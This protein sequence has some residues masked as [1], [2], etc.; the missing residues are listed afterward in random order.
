MK[1]PKCNCKFEFDFSKCPE[2]GY[3]MSYKTDDTSTKPR[4]TSKVIIAAACAAFVIC[5]GTIGLAKLKNNSI[6]NDSKDDAS[7]ASTLETSSAEDNS[8][9]AADGADDSAAELTAEDYKKGGDYTAAESMKTAAASYDPESDTHMYDALKKEFEENYYIEMSTQGAE[10]TFAL[11]DGEI[12][13]SSNYG[14]GTYSGYY[15]KDKD[16]YTISE[17]TKS[18]SKEADFDYD[19]RNSD[20]LFGGTADFI[21]AEID[22]NGNISEVYAIDEDFTQASGTIRY[23]FNKDTGALM[24]Y[25]IT[26]DGMA[27]TFYTIDMLAECADENINL[28]DLSE[29][30][31]M[32]ADTSEAESAAEDTDKAGEE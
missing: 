12:A 4:K 25:V 18:Y 31:D 11:R 29:Y 22:E 5:I 17:V 13:V 9:D 7:Y 24:N 1:C 20:P 14:S 8:A 10:L 27:S 15:T 16:F 32:N 6:N 19:T 28:P 2:C 30:S 26:P 23:T 21:S 3:E